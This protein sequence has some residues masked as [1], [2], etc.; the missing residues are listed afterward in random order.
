MNTL[1]QVQYTTHTLLGQKTQARKLSFVGII[2]QT[3]VKLV[4][5]LKGKEGDATGVKPLWENLP[6]R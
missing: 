6:H 2:D 5:N 1:E 4:C 3:D